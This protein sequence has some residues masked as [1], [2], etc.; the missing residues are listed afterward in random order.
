MKIDK[1]DLWT[2]PADWRVITTNG[3]VKSNGY[4]VMG[5]GNA[6]QATQ[7]FPDLPKILGTKVT[8]GG[9][10]C[11]IVNFQII[12]FPTKH[13]WKDASD[14]KLIEN[15]AKE[16]R[17]LIDLLTVKKA[18]EG[19]SSLEDIELKIVMPPPGCG[20]GGLKWEDVKKVIEPYLDDRFTVLTKGKST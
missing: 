20:L 8:K 17:I 3:V 5:A 16:L 11:Y 9:N 14:I 2:Y 4:L 6:L 15:S 10:H 12:S 13:H 1:G 18:S 19:I 7:K